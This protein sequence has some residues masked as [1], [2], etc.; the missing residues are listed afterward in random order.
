MKNINE[1]NEKFTGTRPANY[2]PLTPIS[3]LSRTQKVFGNKTAVIYGERQY[4]W[5]ELYNRCLKCADALQKHG[6]QYGEVVSVIAFN[7][8][9]M[10]ELQFA[11]AIAGGF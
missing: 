10:V 8:P 4:N 2:V 3:F 11:V 1:I 9:E 5:Q 7:T 6:L